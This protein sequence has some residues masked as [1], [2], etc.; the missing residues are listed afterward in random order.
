MS[1]LRTRKAARESTST[2]DIRKLAADARRAV[3]ASQKEEV[4]LPRLPITKRGRKATSKVR[5][6]LR[7]NAA[8]VG[9]ATFVA[10]RSR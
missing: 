9:R 7:M 5:A 4:T 6:A 2:E 8:N 3:L 10:S 1:S